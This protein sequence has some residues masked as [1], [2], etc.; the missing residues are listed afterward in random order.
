MDEQ[1]PYL[2]RIAS[3]LE[4]IESQN[5]DIVMNLEAIRQELN[6]IDPLSAVGNLKSELEN[7]QS[8]LED[9]S[10]YLRDI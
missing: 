3:S 6:W 10:T 2:E 9:M 4:A 1:M 7:V 5:R 8:S